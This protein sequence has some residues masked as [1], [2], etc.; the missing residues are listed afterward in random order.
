MIFETKYN[1]GD[2]VWLINDNKPLEVEVS[3]I[4]IEQTLDQIGLTTIR[5]YMVRFIHSTNCESGK[6]IDEKLLFRSKK[7]LLESL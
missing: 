1:C 4:R 7:E 5:Y 2:K 3:R 6:W